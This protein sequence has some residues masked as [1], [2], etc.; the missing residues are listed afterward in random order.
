M[1]RVK[2]RQTKVRQGRRGRETRQWK[3]RR[4]RKRRQERKMERDEVVG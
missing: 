2:G 1:L 3:N 4:G